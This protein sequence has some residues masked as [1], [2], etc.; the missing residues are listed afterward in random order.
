MLTSIAVVP[1]SS[2]CSAMLRQRC[3]A[4]NQATPNTTIWIHSRARRPHPAP[5]DQN[6]DAQQDRADDEPPERDRSPA[7]VGR[8]AADDDERARPGDDASRDR[9]DTRPSARCAVADGCR[10]GSGYGPTSATSPEAAWRF[11]QDRPDVSSAVADVAPGDP[12]LDGFQVVVGAGDAQREH[13]GARA[14]AARRH[15]PRCDRAARSRSRSRRGPGRQPRSAPRG[16]P[17]CAAGSSPSEKLCQISAC[18]ATM[19]EASSSRRLRRSGSGCR[20]VGGGLSF[21]QRASMRGRFSAS[22]SRR[23]P[24]V[25]NS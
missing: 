24:T 23:S 1:A 2:V 12:L 4:P 15:P 11:R 17:A 9:D 16:C 25:P 22:A 14:P 19:L 7:E 13:G 5:P 10:H 20:R 21:F 6:D 8:D 3:S 18:C